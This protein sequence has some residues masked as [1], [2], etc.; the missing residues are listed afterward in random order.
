MIGIFETKE[1]IE[2]NNTFSCLYVDPQFMFR[3]YFDKVDSVV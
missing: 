1:Y 3:R 2:K